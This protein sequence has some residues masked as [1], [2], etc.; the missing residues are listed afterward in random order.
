LR[1]RGNLGIGLVILIDD[2]DWPAEDPAAGIDVL[3]SQI[4]PE[5]RLP[6]VKLDPAR[7]RQH[8]T[9]L[10]RFG[11]PCG[12]GTHCPCAADERSTAK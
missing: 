7:E 3:R 6:A 12:G 8:C 1:I 11:G 2:L 5:L 10:D 4:E 9:D